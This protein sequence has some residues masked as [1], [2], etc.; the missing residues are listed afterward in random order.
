MWTITCKLQKKKT[1]SILLSSYYWSESVKYPLLSWHV[2][3]LL[4]LTDTS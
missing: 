1:V 4:A 3:M 2:V